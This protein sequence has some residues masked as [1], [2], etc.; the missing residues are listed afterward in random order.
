MKKRKPPE[1]SA[2]E[3]QSGL[4]YLRGSSCCKY[5]TNLSFAAL[6][7]VKVRETEIDGENSWIITQED[8]KGRVQLHSISDSLH[9]ALK[10][11]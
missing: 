9:I 10:N 2:P 7:S 4:G 8:E 6:T 1:V 3:L 11:R 5:T